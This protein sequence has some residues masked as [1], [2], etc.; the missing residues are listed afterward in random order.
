MCE[1][2]GNFIGE[3]SLEEYCGVIERG[4]SDESFDVFVL[5]DIDI[6]YGEE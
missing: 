3:L 2:K 1:A 5:K 4:Y 6:V